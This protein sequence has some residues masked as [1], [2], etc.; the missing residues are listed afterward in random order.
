[1]LKLHHVRR[2]ALLAVAGFLLAPAPVSAQN[3]AADYPNRPIRSWFQPA[4]GGVDTV[5][6]I[7]ATS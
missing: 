7:V 3:P 6:R 1:M 2:L 5:T 4:G